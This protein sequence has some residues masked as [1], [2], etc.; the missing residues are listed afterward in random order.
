MVTAHS[1]TEST[2]DTYQDS[3]GHQGIPQAQ[4]RPSHYNST[5][6]LERTKAMNLALK[7]ASAEFLACKGPGHASD[8]GNDLAS[9]DTTFPQTPHTSVGMQ[10]LVPPPTAESVSPLNPPVFGGKTQFS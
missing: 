6:T 2:Q 10:V 5:N 4:E 9:E 1:S 3:Q 8:T 7:A